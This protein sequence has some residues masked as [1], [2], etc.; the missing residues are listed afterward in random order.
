MF[1]HMMNLLISFTLAKIIKYQSNYEY[2]F[3]SFVAI[4]IKFFFTINIYVGYNK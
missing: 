2:S 3:T 4:R 1:Y